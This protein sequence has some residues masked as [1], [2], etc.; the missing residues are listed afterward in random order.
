MPRCRRPARRAVSRPV[1]ADETNPAL[2]VDRKLRGASTVGPH[3]AQPAPAVAP[4]D[5]PRSAVACR[6]AIG[7]PILRPFVLGSRVSDAG[8]GSGPGQRAA[9]GEPDAADPAAAAAGSPPPHSATPHPLQGYPNP[10]PRLTP[11]AAA[12]HAR[13]RSHHCRHRVP[14][15]TAEKRAPPAAH[16]PG[17]A[18]VPRSRIWSWVRCGKGWIGLWHFGKRRP[19]G[20]PPELVGLDAALSWRCR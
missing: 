19:S 12:G 10:P 20:A 5:P 13:P 6:S 4:R 7:R 1:C 8:N 17:R 18:R 16:S 2:S 3:T 11:R 15:D 9:R 14:A